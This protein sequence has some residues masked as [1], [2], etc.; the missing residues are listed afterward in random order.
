MKQARRCVPCGGRAARAQ[1]LADD[2]LDPDLAAFDAALAAFKRAVQTADLAL[3]YLAGHAVERH[4]SSYFL[5]VDF[6]FPPT[7]AGL[8]YTA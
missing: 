8:R 2:L 3:I 4:G 6:R 1:V 5:P 7:A